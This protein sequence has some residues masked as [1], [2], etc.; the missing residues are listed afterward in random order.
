MKLFSVDEL[1]SKTAI[2]V[3][4]H[5]NT[6]E[7][8]F[9]LLRRRLAELAFKEI[10]IALGIFEIDE[11]YFGARRVRGKRGRG[12]AGKTPVFGLL[13]RNGKV[14][15]QIVKNCSRD[16]LMP[17]I[18]GKVGHA[19][20]I[21]D[22]TVYSKIQSMKAVKYLLELTN[23][24]NLGKANQQVQKSKALILKSFLDDGVPV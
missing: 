2:I 3:D 20:T 8:I 9:N 5:V 11:S 10:E 19:S 17:I 16:E 22:N 15:T 24:N 12:A 13:K 21:L 6:T 18:Q 23:N 4:V 14:Y 1:T 7:R